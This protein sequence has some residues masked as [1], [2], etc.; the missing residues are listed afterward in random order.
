MLRMWMV[1]NISCNKIIV[2]STISSLSHNL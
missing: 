1:D 2:K